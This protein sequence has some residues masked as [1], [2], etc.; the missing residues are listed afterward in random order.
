MHVHELRH[1]RHP[2]IV[3][4]GANVP[5]EGQSPQTGVGRYGAYVSR[6]TEIKETRG[7]A[8]RVGIRLDKGT[9]DIELVDNRIE[10]VALDVDRRQ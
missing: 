7:P 4:D 5:S 8:K 3:V 1:R 9:R 2:P 6:V 10:G